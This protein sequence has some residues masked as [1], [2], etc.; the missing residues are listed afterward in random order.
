MG[1][2]WGKQT[3]LEKGGEGERGEYLE[4]IVCVMWGSVSS[5]DGEREMSTDRDSEI[6]TDRD[7]QTRLDF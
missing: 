5:G 1:D 2:G 3:E 4:G 6:H 7:T